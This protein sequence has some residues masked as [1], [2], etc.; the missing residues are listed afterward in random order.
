MLAGMLD[1]TASGI[2]RRD[3]LAA[4]AGLVI[5]PAALAQSVP[6]SR[7]TQ[8]SS[9]GVQSAAPA[10]LLACW[11]E[12]FGAAERVRL[13][14]DSAGRI[15]I[16]VDGRT[17][18]GFG[19]VRAFLAAGAVS[20][21]LAMVASVAC[22]PH[23]FR[24]AEPAAWPEVCT[25]TMSAGGSL[26]SPTQLQLELAASISAR[27]QSAVPFRPDRPASDAA[28]RGVGANMSSDRVKA[29]IVEADDR[30][31]FHAA[32]RVLASVPELAATIGPPSHWQEGTVPVVW[33]L[34]RTANPNLLAFVGQRIEAA[35][36]YAFQSGASLDPTL[37]PPETCEGVAAADPEIARALA[38][39]ARLGR[40]DATEPVV[41]ARVGV[42]V[43]ARPR[44]APPFQ[45]MLGGVAVD[46]PAPAATP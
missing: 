6:A 22:V 45:S 32:M 10:A 15:V 41:V 34:P 9:G 39:I 38:T 12:S 31:G 18:E 14:V 7:K 16:A 36:L 13:K 27:V 8:G 40:C 1:P 24:W 29:W 19:L 35:S 26:R 11:A 17:G 5:T 28:V 42:P 21:A 23:A 4:L 2:S 37:L 20:E 25:F 43:E 33:G 3:S 30:A 46:A 44:V